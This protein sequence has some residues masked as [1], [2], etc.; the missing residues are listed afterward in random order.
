MKITEVRVILTCP[1]RNFVF[2]KVMT[3]EPGMYGVGEGTVNGS[4]PIIAKTIEHLSYLLIGRDP[5]AIEDIWQTL[6]HS[7]YWRGGPIFAGAL[8]AIDFALWDIKGK[9]AGLPVYQLL[10]GKAREG[11]AVYGHAAGPTPTAVED[12]ARSFMAKGYKY[13]RAQLSGGYGGYGGPGMHRHEDSTIP[14][15][16]GTDYFNPAP[17]LNSTPKLF[18]HLRLTLGTDD[19]ELLHD[20][21]EQLTPIEAAQLAKNLEPYRLFYLED[22]L[23]PEQK[24]HFPLVRQASTTALAIG[25]IISSRWDCLPLF[26]NHWIDFIRIA[27]IHVGGI[28]EA[29]KICVLAET[30]FVRTAFHGAMDLGPIGQAAAVHLDLAIPN[31]GVQEWVSFPEQLQEVVTGLCYLQDG[32]AYPQ[33]KPGLGVDID[34]AAAQKYPYERAYMPTVR[35]IDG[36]MHVY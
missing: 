4:E 26:Q 8:A 1:S 33:E 14:G 22:P 28:T 31:F 20:V 6:Y 18:E 29:R 23:R 17:Y 34:E 3:D 30:Y 7:G 35:R 5:A 2:V 15:H 24:E 32:Y 27:P 11:A 25:E 13:I 9:V 10:G 19:I 21:H 12:A 36:T 16:K